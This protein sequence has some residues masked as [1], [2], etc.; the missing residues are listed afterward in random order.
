MEIL[1]CVSILLV[2]ALVGLVFIYIKEKKKFNGQN[3]SG[4]T[5]AEKNEIKEDL[6]RAEPD[7]QGSKGQIQKCEAENLQAAAANSGVRET[8]YS[9]VCPHCETINPRGLKRCIACA[10]KAD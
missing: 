4:E 10:C 2:I 3:H 5:A 1:F 9:W 7:L 8:E 6:R